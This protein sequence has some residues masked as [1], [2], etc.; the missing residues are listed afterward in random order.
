[1]S[2]IGNVITALIE[3]HS[4]GE[5][6]DIMAMAEDMGIHI[7]S[8]EMELSTDVAVMKQGEED[9]RP[10]IE[11]NSI[12]TIEQNY[13]LVALLLADC[14]IA[15]EKASNEG[16]K[17]EIFFLKDLRDYRLTRT[18]LLATRLAIPEKIINQIDE[19]DFNIDE[20]IA[21]TNYLPSFVNNMV[22]SSNAS[23]LFINDLIGVVPIDHLLKCNAK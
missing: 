18:L 15:P 8:V 16:F 9:C 21:K 14:F 4:Q 5:V 11:L 20:Y 1:M 2:S 13:T 6:I 19:F 22:K 17:Y 3:K 12:N 23:F 7:S 10:K